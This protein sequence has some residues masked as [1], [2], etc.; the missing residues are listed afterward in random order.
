[1]AGI[2]VYD[3][4]SSMLRS[5]MLEAQPAI[6]ALLLNLLSL[7]T[8]TLSGCRDALKLVNIELEDRNI[9]VEMVHSLGDDGR[10]YPILVG[11]LG[12]RTTTPTVLL[13]A[14]VDT[15]PAGPGWS[16]RIPQAN[17]SLTIFMDA[18]R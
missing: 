1:M 6:R 18:E 12:R 10:D 13:C 8:E 9:P 16:R 3:E 4:R 2:D 15:S 14:H 17:Y 7:N 11:W 5:Q